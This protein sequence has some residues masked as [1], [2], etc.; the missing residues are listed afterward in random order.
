MELQNQAPASDTVR[1]SRLRVEVPLLGFRDHTNLVFTTPDK[2]LPTTISLYFNGL[3]L[4]QGAGED[5]VMSESGGPGS[6]YDT[7]TLLDVVLAPY[8]TEQLFADYIQ[9]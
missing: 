3:R 4:R 7:I 8:S 6:G 1:L 9:A 5:Y 2:F